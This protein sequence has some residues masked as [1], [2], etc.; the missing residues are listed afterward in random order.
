[1]KLAETDNRKRR[2]RKGAFVIREADL[3]Q[4]SEAQ[5]ESLPQPI[6]LRGKR[7]LDWILTAT[8]G[9]LALPLVML[10]AVLIKCISP[11]PAFYGQT[12]IGQHGKIFR[13][14]KL[15]TMVN[16]AEARLQAYLKTNGE[17]RREWENGCKLKNDPRVIPL[18]GKGLRS[19][20]LDE[21]PQIWNVAVGDMSWVGP[22]PFP[23]YH[24][25]HLDDDFRR[26]REAMAPG[27]TGLW[28]VE[29]RGD[30][31]P[32]TI[33]RWD[34]FYAQHRSIWMDVQILAR[35]PWT[36]LSGMFPRNSPRQNKC[37]AS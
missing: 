6:S 1:M 7:A 14:W 18:I 12:R 11:G 29:H 9:I 5:V 31:S 15:R 13:I 20:G 28:Q 32:K 34:T 33:Q 16:D 27:I 24:L 23:E 22:R 2:R 8:F 36:M 19:S 10:L 25:E 35:T 26:I 21:L 37:D 4:A 30:H 3:A 17:A